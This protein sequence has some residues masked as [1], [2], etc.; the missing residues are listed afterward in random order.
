MDWSKVDE[1]IRAF[2]SLCPA[3]RTKMKEFG[4]SSC[5]KPPVVCDKCKELM[6]QR[7]EESRREG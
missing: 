1:K 2:D 5:R 7:L 3:C 6:K 4:T